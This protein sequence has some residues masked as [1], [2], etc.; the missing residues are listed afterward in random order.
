MILFENLFS[1]NNVLDFCVYFVFNVSA[2]DAINSLYLII[3]NQQ[4]TRLRSLIPTL[5]KHTNITLNQIEFLKP[6]QRHIQSQIT[7]LLKDLVS[8]AWSDAAEDWEPVGI[9]F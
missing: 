7:P 4:I 3:N 2:E 9:T 6:Q 1:C 5:I 8:V